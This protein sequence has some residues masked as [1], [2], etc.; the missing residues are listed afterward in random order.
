MKTFGG[1][2]IRQVRQQAPTNHLQE[3]L[4]MALRLF[5]ES[6]SYQRLVI[7]QLIF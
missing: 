4:L 6:I 1:N 7:T 2:P 5:L 3:Q